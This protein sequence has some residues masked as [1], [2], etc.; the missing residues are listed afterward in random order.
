[1][2]LGGLF[3]GAPNQEAPVKVQRGVWH[4]P[5]RDGRSTDQ[6]AL[7]QG[8]KMQVLIFYGFLCNENCMV[9]KMRIT[10][11]KGAPLWADCINNEKQGRRG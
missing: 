10:S 5:A 9:L 7:I 6:T 1:M 3:G 2:F 11:G 8:M 4:L